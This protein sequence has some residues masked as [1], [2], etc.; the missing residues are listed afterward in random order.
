MQVQQVQ[1]L[2][3]ARHHAA[4]T[5]EKPQ[6]AR[7]AAPNLGGCPLRRQNATHVKSLK[8]TRDCR[9]AMASPAHRTSARWLVCW[10]RPAIS[11]AQ[12]L[13][14]ASICCCSGRQRG[15]GRV[16]TCDVLSARCQVPSAVYH[17]AAV[18]FPQSLSGT[19]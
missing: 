5:T 14:L 16:H 9:P 2:S 4:R 12:R 11:M 15:R 1:V 7:T 3:V 10:C 13:W 18:A 19:A 8:Q 17:P 6:E